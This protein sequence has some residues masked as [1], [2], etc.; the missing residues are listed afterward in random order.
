MMLGA[1]GKEVER[2]GVI[3][4]DTAA[5]M[6]VLDTTPSK[7]TGVTPGPIDSIGSD[8][9]A[10]PPTILSAVAASDSAAGSLLFHG[11]GRCFTCHGEGGQGTP[12]LGSALTDTDWSSGNGSLA[13]IVDVMTHG[14]AL[15]ERGSVAMP[16]YAGM[17]TA[18][19]IALTAAYVYTLSHPGSTAVDSGTAGAG[20]TSTS[21]DSSA[22]QVAR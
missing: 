2:G 6:P 12:R 3:P 19:E 11:K 13:S 10:A 14:V 8:S 9:A 1:C 21:S 18:R 7:T 20:D 16:G 5:I 15:P 22:G 17:L 4:V